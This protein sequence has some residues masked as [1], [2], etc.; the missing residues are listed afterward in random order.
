MQSLLFP[1]LKALW[2]SML[3]ENEL[4]EGVGDVLVV[5]KRIIQLAGG[6]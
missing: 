4:N 3:A 5:G 6:A 2:R 1:G